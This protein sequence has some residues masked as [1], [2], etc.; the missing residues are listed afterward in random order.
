ATCTLKGLGVVDADYPYYLGM[1][2]MH[3][4]KAANLAVQESDLLIAVGAR[5]D[6]RVTGKLNTFAPHAKVIHMDIDPAELN[7][8]RQ[9][10][11]GLTGDLNCLLPALQQ[12][13]AIDGWRERSA[14]L[15]AEHAWRYDHPGEAIY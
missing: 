9:A 7:K 1:L 11:I 5:F 6:D 12:P 4:T 2:G 10:H 8:L 3:G 14:A 15:R 13:L